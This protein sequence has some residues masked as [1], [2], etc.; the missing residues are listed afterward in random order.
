MADTS[1]TRSAGS[2]NGVIL[3]MCGVLYDSGEDGG[4]AIPGSVEAVNRLK[5][6]DLKL[7]F[8]TNET[9]A[10]RETFVAK[11]RRM[12]F[13][14][15]VCDVFSPAPAAAAVLTERGLRPH[16]LVYD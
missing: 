15:S 11:L 16:L 9:Q 8:C 1:W 14:V 5:A 4:T 10:S 13:D 6:S 3:D 12:G 7:R 2:I